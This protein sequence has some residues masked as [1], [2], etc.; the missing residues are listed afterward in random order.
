MFTPHVLYKSPR[1]FREIRIEVGPRAWTANAD[2]DLLVESEWARLRAERS[3]WDGTYYRTLSP[4]DLAFR[5]VVQLGTIAYRYIATYRALHRYHAKWSLQPLHH[6]STVALVCT[7]DGKYLFGRRSLNGSIDLIGGGVQC[8]EL[9]VSCGADLECNLYK[10]IFEETGITGE[11][12]SDLC[13]LGALVSSTSNVLLL[14]RVHL[15][16]SEARVR[17]LFAARTDS[18]MAEPI[19]VQE[20]Q[21]PSFLLA[22]PDY[23][24]LIP[25][26]L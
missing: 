23:R 22:L 7:S 21:L 25:E 17:A 10:E 18:E 15:R 13:G 24:A 2:Y 9:P 6:L 8:D 16:V 1:S 5:P 11:E 26:L 12:I 19:F 20:V 14:A 4:G 3:L